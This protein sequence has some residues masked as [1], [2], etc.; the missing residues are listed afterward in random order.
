M[1]LTAVAVAVQR[2]AEV[3]PIDGW[4]EPLNIFAAPLMRSGERKSAI[5][6]AI[7][8]PIEEW[9]A[10]ESARVSVELLDYQTQR[11][12][13]EG[14]HKK[15][16]KAAIEAQ[17]AEDRRAAMEQAQQLGREL[18]GMPERFAP[19]LLA[20]DATPETLKTLLFEQGGRLGILSTEG[21]V[22]EQLAGRYSANGGANAEVYLQAH[23]G[24]TLLVDR[25][26]RNEK[27][28]DPALTIGILVQ[29]DV[30]RTFAKHPELRERG[31]V[32]RWAF[33]LPPSLVGDRD[34]DP[35][36]V[37]AALRAGYAE[38]IK[39][40]L[41]LPYPEG[42]HD[43]FHTLRFDAHAARMFR[44]FRATIER[45]LRPYEQLDDLADWGSKH[46]GL[47]ARIA[48]LLH[49]MKHAGAASPWDEPTDGPKK[50]G[51]WDEPIDGT[52][53]AGAIAIGEYLIPH[54]LAAAGL[55]G[56]DVGTADA[57][58]LVGWLR[59]HP[60]DTLRHQTIWQGTKGR[61]GKEERLRGAIAVAI[62]HGYLRELPR[63]QRIGGGITP[64]T[65]ALNPF[66]GP[67]SPKSPNSSDCSGQLGELGDLG[68]GYENAYEATGTEEVGEL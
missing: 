40:L 2:K 68:Q 18:L 36:P 16:K 50:T 10:A 65:Y 28:F 41:D 17:N 31:L 15:A 32:A 64:R 60:A 21:T 54:T 22:V 42:R 12:V 56:L 1:V 26:G 35:P 49:M 55:M 45:S 11:E 13:L 39:H 63:E 47:V 67:K 23:A 44:A 4:D 66:L 51:P 37:P 5:V 61:F 57:R 25:R 7:R 9:E 53:M 43:T 62:D 58:Y 3:R 29:P 14:Q 27:I 24:D 34:L 59:R 20:D 19:R 48:G 52:T 33:A 46:P 6:R 8:R 38:M 30:L